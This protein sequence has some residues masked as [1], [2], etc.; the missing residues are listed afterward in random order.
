MLKNR[1]DYSKSEGWY[2]SKEERKSEHSRE[3]W[4]VK[5]SDQRI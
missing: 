4:M 5:V 3:I 2:I 1:W